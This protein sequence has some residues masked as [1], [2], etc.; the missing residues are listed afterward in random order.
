MHK[1]SHQSNT[2]VQDMH[3]PEMHQMAEQVQEASRKHEKEERE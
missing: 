2:P 1:N 3:L